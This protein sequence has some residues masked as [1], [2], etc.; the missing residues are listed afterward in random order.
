[1]ITINANTKIS[2]LLREHPDALEAIISLSPKFTKL[3]NPLL[4]KLMASRATI[5]M[6]S[7]IGG[8]TPEDFFAKLE[9]LG[10]A[11]DRAASDEAEPQPA[12]LPEF[13]KQV[14]PDNV[15]ELDVRPIL[16]AGKDPFNVILKQ[17]QTMEPRQTLKL[18]NDFEPIPLIL[19]LGKQGFQS[20][21]EIVD[22]NT[23]NTYFFKAENVDLPDANALGSSDDF[24]TKVK[25]FEGRTKT[26][27]VR[28]LEMPLPMLTILDELDNL[29][30]DQAL[31]V[32]HKR[33]PVFLLPELE[34]RKFEYRAKEISEGDV[35][36]FIFR[37]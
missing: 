33:I 1:M 8:C 25:Q 12:P 26:I 31:Y 37:P 2:A 14:S 35:K 3:R 36:L 24:E 28:H 23:Y 20:Y 30:A 21:S 19:M 15:V 16:N 6:A 27:D 22:G 4:R 18:I 17:V 29:P 34:E 9:P 13:M 32:N 10:F 7:K 5:R 11:I